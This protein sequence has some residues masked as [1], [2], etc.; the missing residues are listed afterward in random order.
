MRIWFFFLASTLVCFGQSAPPPGSEAE[1]YH[2]MLLKRPQPGLVYDR[3]YSAWMETGTADSLAAFLSARTTTAADLLLLAIFHDQ[4][5]NEAE[6]LKAYTSALERDGSNARAWLQ[7]AKLEARMMNFETALKSLASADKTSSETAMAREIGQLRGRW[8]LRTGKPDAALQAWR[9]LLKASADDED[10]VEEVVDLQL[11]EGLFS[12]AEAQMQALISKTKDAYAKVVR[13]LRLAEIQLRATKKEAALAM[14]TE[15]LANTGQGTWIE[16]EVLAQIEATFRRD[17]NLSGLVKELEKLQAAHPQRT[18]LERQR[19]RLLAELGEKDKALAA[20]AALLQKTPG[21]RDL[22]ESYLDLLARFEQFKEAIAQTRVLLE[23]SPEDRELLIRLATLQERAKDMPA[24]KATLEKFLAAKDAAEFDHLRVARLYES[25]DRVDEATQAY[26]R[27]VAAFPDSSAA[28]EAQAH[29]LHRSGKRDAALAIWHALAKN[30]DL[31]QVMAVGQALMARI[32]SQAALEVLQQRHAEFASDDRFLALLIN[33]ALSAKKPVDAIPWALA[34]A[35]ATTDVAFMDDALRQVILCLN[36]DE[37]KYA[38][39]LA[40]LQKGT[41]TVQERMLLSALLEEKQDRM[42]AEKT[43]REIPPEHALAAQ[44]RLLKLMESRQDWLGASAEAEKLIAMPQG[45]TSTN[46]QRLVDLAERAG[47]P[48]QAL[49]WVADWKTLSP[50]SSSPWLREAK[51]LQLDGKGREALKVLQAAARKFAD[52]EAV[53]DSLASAYTEL[54]Q[55]SDAEK[56]YLSLFE[57]EDK[58]EDKMRWVGTLARLANDRGQLKALIEKFIDRQRTNRA[59]AAPWLALAEIYRVAGN[60]TEQERSLREAMRLR[61]EDANLAMQIARAELDMGQWK[62]AIED[63]QRVASRAKGGRVQQMIASIQIEYGDANAGYRMLYELAGGAQMDADDAITLAKSMSAQQEWSRMVSFLEPLLRRYPDDYRLAYLQA[64]AL[65]ESGK[66]DPSASLFIRLMAQ[67]Q[68]LPSIVASTKTKAVN[69]FDTDWVEKNMPKGYV[70]LAR[71]TGSGTYYQAYNYRSQSYRMAGQNSKAVITPADLGHLKAASLVHLV[72]LMKGEP[73]QKQK[74]WMTDAMSAG[75]PGAGYLDALDVDQYFNLRESPDAQEKHP[76]DDVLLAWIIENAEN[77][78]FETAAKSFERFKGRFQ[79]LAFRAAVVAVR[80][81]ADR[82]PP[83]LTEA[84][85]LWDKAPSEEKKKYGVVDYSLRSMLGGNQSMREEEESSGVLPAPLRRRIL[86]LILSKLDDTYEGAQQQKVYHT[87]LPFDAN[88]CRT[89][90]A[91]KEFAALLER[92]VRIW[93]EHEPTRQEWIKYAAQFQRRTRNPVVETISRLPFPSGTQVPPQMVFYFGRKDMYNARDDDKLE[94]EPEEYAGLKPFIA[95]MKS[96]VLRALLFYKAGDRSLAEKEIT[97]LL[98]APAPSVDDILLAA[99]WFGIEEKYDRVAALLLQAASMNVPLGVRPAFDTA[100]AHVALKLKP[101]PGSPLLEPAQMALRRMRSA[102]V[103]VEQKEELI[104]AMKSLGMQDEAE[105]WARIAMAPAPAVS[106]RTQSYVSTS[107][108]DTNKLKTLLAGGEDEAILKEAVVQLRRALAYA[109]NGNGSYASSRAKEI[110]RLVT[111]PGMGAKIRA[112]FDPGETASVAKLFEQAQFLMLIE[113]KLEAVKVLEKIL[114]VNPQHFEARLHLCAIIATTNSERAVKMMSEVPLSAFQQSGTGNLVTDMLNRNDSVGFEARM[115]IITVLTRVLDSL[116]SGSGVKGLEWMIDLPGITANSTYRAPRLR[117]LYSRPGYSMEDEDD[118]DGCL[119]ASSPEALKRREVH[120]RLCLALMKHPAL[121]EEGFR[122]FACLVISEG[123]KMEELASTAHRL[124]EEATTAQGTKRSAGLNRRYNFYQEVTGLW[125]PTPAEFLVWKAWKENHPER[126]A[127]EIMPLASAALDATRLGVLRAQWNVWSCKPEDFIQK[128]RAFLTTISSR[129]SF[130]Y[131]NDPHL[132]WLTDRWEE[133]NLAGTPLDELIAGGMKQVRNFGEGYAVS[134]YLSA[135]HRL[136]PDAAVEPFLIQII[137]GALGANQSTWAKTIGTTIDARYGRGGSFNNPS[138]YT[139]LQIIDNM[140]RKPVTFG[141]GLQMAVLVGANENSNWLRNVGY[142]IERVTKSP[143]HVISSL[144]ALGFL[145]GPEQIILTNDSNCVQVV[146]LKK[147]REHRDTMGEVRTKLA[148]REQRTFGA[149]FCEAFLQDAPAGPLTALLKRRAADV[150]KI[151]VK[152]G[153]AFISLLKSQITALGQPASADPALV[154]ALDPLLG[155]E[156]QKA[157]AEI[158]KWIAA[159]RTEDVHSDPGTYA[160]KVKDMLKTLIPGDLDK[161]QKLFLHAC[162]IMEVKIRAGGWNGYS[163]ANAWTSRS[164]ILDEL[165][166]EWPKP[167]TMAFVMRLCH[168]DTTGNLSSDGWAA[169]SGYGQVLV[170][171]WRNNGGAATMGRGIDAM[172]ARTAEVLQDTPHTL[173]PLAFFDFYQRLPQSLRVPAMKYAAKLPASHPQLAL[174][175]ELDFAGRFFLSTDPQ[176]RQNAGFQK[177]IEE[178]GG[179]QLA[180]EHHR[181]LL[182]ADKASPRVRQALV[183]FL[184]Y[185]SHDDIDPECTRLGAAAALVSMKQKDCIHGYQYGWILRAF[186]LLPVDEAWLAEAQQHW[187]AWMARSINGGMSKYE[188]CDWVINSMLRMTARSGKDDWMREMLRRFHHTFS[189]EQSAIVSLM[190]GGQPKLAAEHFKS[191]WRG[192]LM[193][194]QKELLWSKEIVSNLPAFKEA[195]G[196]PGLALLGEIYLSYIKDPS[197]A[198]QS[199]IPGF[200]GRDD[201]FIDIAKRLKDTKFTDEEMR[202]DCVE[203][204]CNVYGAADA[205]RDVV[206]EVAAKTNI[207]AI[208]AL[209]HTWEH[210]RQLKPV[211]FAY[212][213]KAAHGDLQPALAAYDRALSVRSSSSYLQRSVLKESGWGP[214]WVASWHWGRESEAGRVPEIR[215]LL[216]FHDHVIS[217]TPPEMRD[218]HVSDC[219]SQKWFIHLA[220]NEPEVF[221]SW[222]KGLKEEDRRDFKKRVIEDWDIWSFVRQYSGTQKKMRLTPEERAGLVAAVA[223]DEWCAAKYPAAGPGIP[224]LIADIVQ[225]STVFKPDEL[226]PVAAQI[227]TALPRMGRTAGEAGDL[228][229][230][231]GKN[232]AAVPLFALAFEHARKGNEKDYNLAAGYAVKQAEILERTGKKLE[233]LQVLKSL[234]EKRLGGGVKKTVE[235]A[236]TRLSK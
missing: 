201:R 173:M 23:Q 216:P 99:S 210:W 96:P 35:R 22:R 44:T 98:A 1:K 202:K 213:W 153:P 20:Y 26:E 115:N 18:A 116:P 149:E 189:N 152:S 3:F 133:R 109:S 106:P 147:V 41:P 16:G 124:L 56:I 33:A 10:L 145:G 126:V 81:D 101:Q 198:E 215:A 113:Q 119:P 203:V 231:N 114:T 117:H 50:G 128:S 82:G 15:T 227:A 214:T 191:E 65:E 103:S 54:G 158:D 169:N 97:Q 161:A 84:L 76:D 92:E 78:N 196:D 211:Q 4:R 59:D 217:K 176:S 151:P 130:G 102:R 47:K 6:A 48:D 39:T 94:P 79:M 104:A 75:V 107:S 143:Q 146:F 24:S 127:Q 142:N 188:P 63:L 111:R 226:V 21:Q 57:K 197:K 134:H 184:S 136:R 49:K 163:G 190:L 8:L 221:A 157:M 122:R 19:A 167:E 207:E 168:E 5:G 12:E 60:T 192:F 70:G 17:E 155:A 164:N 85:D 204:L 34:R 141:P 32:E 91:W 187:D 125:A 137:A 118:D 206:D 180:W 195:C 66:S 58:P 220:L 55:M 200:K 178:L 100:L 212:G 71:L 61:P 69:Q 31:P 7:R 233:A 159:A 160:E 123:N 193:D 36:A 9:D 208:A 120:D 40:A 186:N 234:E 73:A 230:A 179:M 154:T 182:R 162:E 150:A 29:Y 170:E 205:I 37:V 183:H 112:V 138:A 64:V 88:A 13:Q 68:E 172:L 53:A 165:K 2:L 148:E 62:R 72:S 219:V 139:M 14:M 228:L 83:L 121:A 185:W 225:K 42:G 25:W 209:D 129:G 232:E 132:V 77:L 30:G 46:L 51:L 235:T 199:S 108:I 11:D 45:R 67:S 229:A 87:F 93:T 90:E 175:R 177:A 144:E 222:R 27:M 181:T 224:N 105:Q 110:M 140:I 95:G 171:I 86:T 194:P 131:G 236:I 174:G 43:L 166:K 74:A 52:D 89:Q 156:R 223:R 38:D 80:A 135:R 28:R 218:D